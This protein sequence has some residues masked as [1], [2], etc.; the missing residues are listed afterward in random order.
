[1]SENVDPEIDAIKVVLEALTPL[2]E[3]ARVSVLDYVVKRLNVAGLAS[4]R[5]APSQSPLPSP[6]A[7]E[8]VQ[9]APEKHIKT[10][11]AEKKPRSAN[12]MAALVAYYLGNVAPK[13]QR[14]TDVTREDIETYFKIAEFPLPN[15][16]QVTLP[17]A[18]NAG[19]FDS[20]GDG[21][22]KLNAVGYNL[23][24]HSMPRGRSKNGAKIAKKKARKSRRR[25]NTRKKN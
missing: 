4:E 8:A 18:R 21:K 12:E 15:Q 6:G 5:Q 10:L 1:M 17:N 7:G 16:P 14:K 11:R 3:K 22:Y 9:K 13:D 23:V 24:V 25:R 2:S 20:A 19:Y